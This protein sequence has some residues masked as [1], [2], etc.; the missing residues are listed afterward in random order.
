MTGQMVKKTY[1]GA[2]SGAKTRLAS[3]CDLHAPQQ[4]LA[5]RNQWLVLGL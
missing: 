3:A 2:A 1:K 4:P 5:K